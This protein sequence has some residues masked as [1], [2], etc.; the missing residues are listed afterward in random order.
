MGMAQE[1]MGTRTMPGEVEGEE[2]GIIGVLGKMMMR[3]WS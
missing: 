3:R 2:E 1:D